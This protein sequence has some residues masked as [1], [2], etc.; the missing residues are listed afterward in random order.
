MSTPVFEGTCHGEIWAKEALEQ[1]LEQALSD[2]HANK[3]NLIL[4]EIAGL[5]IEIDRNDLSLCVI[6]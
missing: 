4:I 1:Q 3:S 5:K 2:L 6:T